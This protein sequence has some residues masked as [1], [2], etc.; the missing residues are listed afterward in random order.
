[1]D[2]LEYTVA[3]ALALTIIGVLADSVST[4]HESRLTSRSSDT[5]DETS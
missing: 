2:I 4:W 5:V 3:I 1:M